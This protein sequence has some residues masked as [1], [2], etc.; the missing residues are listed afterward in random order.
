MKIVLALTIFVCIVFMSIGYSALNAELKISGEATVRIYD[1]IEV[2]NIYV[3]NTANNAEEAYNSTHTVDTSNM[4]I[5]LPYENSQMTLVVE[6]TNFSNDIHHLDSVVELSNS[7]SDITYEI[8]DKEVL[9]FPGNSITEIEITF[10]YNNYTVGNNNIN[11][12][13]NYNFEK[14]SYQNLEYIVYSGN[15]YIDS[16][17]VNTGNY[18]FETEFN[19]TGYTGDGGWIVSGRV[20]SSHTLGVFLGTSG[21]FSI[22]GGPSVSRTPVIS[23]NT[24]WHTFYFSRTQSIISGRNYYVSGQTLIDPAYAANIRIGGATIA[25]TG[26]ADTRHFIGYMKKFKITNA[27]TGE[28]LRYFVPA[29]LNDTGEVGFWDVINNEF[30]SNDGT[31]E[32]LAP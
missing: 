26:G 8:K 27:N 10:Y 13:L 32:F 30:Y 28:I 1:K 6:I 22:Y 21:V 19:L 2:T 31:E 20:N 5:I 7:N 23:P 17:L 16:G 11:L 4:G 9:Y 24:G 29:K 15:Q 25:Y 14:I 18:I 12:N 3:K